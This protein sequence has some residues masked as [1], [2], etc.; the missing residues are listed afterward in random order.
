MLEIEVTTGHLLLLE[1]S[2]VVEHTFLLEQ[3]SPGFRGSACG[4]RPL[5]S[6]MP[7]AG[8]ALPPR[9]PEL[10][11]STL[12]PLRCSVS[13]SPQVASSRHV[14]LNTVY[15]LLNPEIYS[16]AWSPCEQRG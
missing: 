7:F 9:L 8:L 16:R 5:S 14:M 12:N 3:G 2:N 13:I 11:L 10:G 15:M 6:W 1:H 4:N